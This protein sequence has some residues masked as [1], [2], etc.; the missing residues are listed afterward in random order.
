MG[1]PKNA[2]GAINDI[3]NGL[4]ALMPLAQKQRNDRGARLRQAESELFQASIRSDRPIARAE[5]LANAERD[6]SQGKQRLRD[7]AIYRAQLA[8]RGW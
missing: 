3:L 1:K 8:R 6:V 2:S 4:D 7:V 5:R